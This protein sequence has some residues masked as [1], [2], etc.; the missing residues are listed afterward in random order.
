MNYEG[1]HEFKGIKGRYTMS[2]LVRKIQ[3]HADKKAG[4]F[5]SPMSA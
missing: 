2:Q 5:Q 4:R 1:L 3:R